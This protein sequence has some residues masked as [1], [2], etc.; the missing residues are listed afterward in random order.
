MY[1][2]AYFQFIEAIDCQEYSD[3][4]WQYVENSL[5]KTITKYQ[6][7]AESTGSRQEFEELLCKLVSSVDKTT[8]T[9]YTLRSNSI[10]RTLYACT[11]MYEYIIISIASLHKILYIYTHSI[12]HHTGTFK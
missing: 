7:S 6:V 9:S 10:L 12:C 8:V 4:V 2:H 1:V 3:L 11:L 5:S